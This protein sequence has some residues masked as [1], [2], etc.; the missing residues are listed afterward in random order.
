MEKDGFVYDHFGIPTDA[1]SSDMDYMSELKLYVTDSN[2]NRF[3]LEWLYFEDDSPIPQKIRRLPHVAFRVN[4]LDEALV[5]HRALF[6]PRQLGNE[7]R[8]AFIES[9]GAPI[10][11]IQML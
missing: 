7:L 11:L 10:E 3:G 5:G 2:A 8:F 1:I 6:G 9:D 4:D